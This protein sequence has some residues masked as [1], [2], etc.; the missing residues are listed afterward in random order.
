[1]K[2]AQLTAFGRPSEVVDCIEAPECGPPGRGEVLVDMAYCPINPADLLIIEGRYASRPDLPASL[3]IEGA[4][5]IA[6]VGEAV[7][8][9]APGDPVMS[10]ARANW[11][12]SI[13]IPAEQ[14]VPLPPKADLQQAAMLKANPAT[15]AL[16]LRDTIDLQ[17]GDWVIQNA[18]NSGVG[19]CLIRLARARGL[20]TVNLVR[21]ES[22]VAPLAEIGADLAVVDGEDLAGRVRNGVGDGQIRLAIDAV[23]GGAT[24][25]LAACLDEGGTIV[26]YGFLSGEPCHVSP[27]ELVFRGITLTGFW[28]AKVLPRMPP[29]SVRGLYRDLAARIADGALFV[30]V[31]QVYPLSEIKAALEHAGRAGRDGKVLLAPGG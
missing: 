24:Q 17:P 25:R 14:A 18:A 15:A 27:N 7:T 6:A 3:G 8:D 22:L 1:M 20:K 2:I 5:R 9:L 19:K 16:M 12:G 31:E 28:L 30:D 4:G 23:G 21:R 26:N 13:R 11:A 29:Q 10:L